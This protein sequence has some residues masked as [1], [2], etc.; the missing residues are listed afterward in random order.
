MNDANLHQ[1]AS[2]HHFNSL[3]LKYPHCYECIHVKFLKYIL[4]GLTLFE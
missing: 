4:K 3:F 2:P 1:Y